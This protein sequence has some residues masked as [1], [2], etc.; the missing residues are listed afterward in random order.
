MMRHYEQF[1]VMNL[2]TLRILLRLLLEHP[3]LFIMVRK[4]HQNSQLKNSKIPRKKLLLR[5]CV[6]DTVFL[7]NYF[8]YYLLFKSIIFFP[9]SLPW[10]LRSKQ[11]IRSSKTKK[12]LWYSLWIES[13]RTKPPSY[14]SNSKKDKI[15][16]KRWHK[17]VIYEG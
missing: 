11:Y 9:T 3:P 16:S 13:W 7:Y 4:T 6:T 14:I 8:W 15:N 2:K 17:F 10:Q 1:I 5:R 12:N